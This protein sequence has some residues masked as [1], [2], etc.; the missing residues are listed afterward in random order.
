MTLFPRVKV[1][2]KVAKMF[3]NL[4]LRNKTRDG[5]YIIWMTDLDSV[6]G[7]TLAER[8]KYVGGALLT[9]EEAKAERNGTAETYAY[10]YTPVYL[11]KDADVEKGEKTAEGNEDSTV[12]VDPVEPV[13]PVVIPD[14]TENSEDA[15]TTAGVENEN[16]NN[17]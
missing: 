16:K 15:A 5:N 14:T 17:K 9:P 2:T 1:T 13:T 4:N 10:V 7:V 8:V 11:D 3:A 12:D 6:P